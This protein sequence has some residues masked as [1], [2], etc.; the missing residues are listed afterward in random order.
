MTDVCPTRAT[1]A[2]SSLCGFGT[3]SSFKPGKM[4]G[5]V[6]PVSATRKAAGCVRG[7]VVCERAGEAIPWREAG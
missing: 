3:T 5:R 7:W 1:A 6:A 2:V 4:N